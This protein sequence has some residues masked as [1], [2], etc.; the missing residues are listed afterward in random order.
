MT[1]RTNNEKCP[2]RLL[3]W[4]NNEA[5]WLSLYFIACLEFF[6]SVKEF[7]KWPRIYFGLADF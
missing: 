7:S 3:I 4:I 2:Q 6:Y 5:R 1:V